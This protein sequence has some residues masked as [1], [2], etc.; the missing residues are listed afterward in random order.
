M[1]IENIYVKYSRL[2][3]VYTVFPTSE[4][5]QSTGLVSRLIEN[6]TTRAK[7]IQNLI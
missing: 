7:T 4:P 5:Y 1:Q 3:I 2:K 6:Y